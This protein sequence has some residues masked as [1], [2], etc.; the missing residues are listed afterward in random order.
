MTCA[1]TRV[2]QDQQILEDNRVSTSNGTV[3]DVK[4]KLSKNKNVK[5]KG[6]G[7]LRSL[8]SQ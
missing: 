2:G 4:E 1:N 6:V 5:I 3:V 8:E 7:S